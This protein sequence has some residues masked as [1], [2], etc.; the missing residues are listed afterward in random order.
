MYTYIIY[1]A[2]I[3]DSPYLRFSMYEPQWFPLPEL[4]QDPPRSVPQNNVQTDIEASMG[5]R[6][7][8]LD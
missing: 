4:S 7:D 1:L 2:G 3:S 6:T 8:K 5:F